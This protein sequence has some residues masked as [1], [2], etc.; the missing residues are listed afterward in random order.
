MRILKIYTTT[1]RPIIKLTSFTNDT[2]ILNIKR[3]M[4]QSNNAAIIAVMTQS[5]IPN[6][7][8]PLEQ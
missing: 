4:I 6:M 8:T 5:N 1:T 2:T 3:I 7:V